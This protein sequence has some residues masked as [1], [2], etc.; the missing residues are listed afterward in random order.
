MIKI[1]LITGFLGAGKTTFLN[2]YANYLIENGKNICI[3]ENDFGA[4]N[5]DMMLIDKLECDKEMV[6]GGCDYDCHFRRFKTKLI[7]MAL[8]GYDRVIVEPSGLFH[9]DEFFDALAEEPLSNFYEIGNIFCLYDIN[10]K[11]LSEEAKSYLASEIS[12]SGKVIVTKRD[13]ND[14][15]VN[16]DYI[17]AVLIEFN[18]DRL[19]TINDII[20]NDDFDVSKILNVGYNQSSTKKLFTTDK[21]FDSI[22]FLDTKLS[23]DDIKNKADLILNDKTFGNVVRIKGFVK[24]DDIWYRI[25][26]TKEEKDISKIDTGQNVFIVIGE[27]LN[28]EKIN[29]IFM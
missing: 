26:I 22:Y 14:I 27:D 29:N 24:K 28:K 3:L 8:R 18:S 11:D 15:K 1:D 9:T 23:L 4:I 2:K 6:A 12:V 10:T 20:Y 16:I 13:N 25:N 7:S 17:N 21:T 19:I 5:V